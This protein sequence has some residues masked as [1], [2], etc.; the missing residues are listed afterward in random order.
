MSHKI[1]LSII[2][3]AY[4]EENHLKHCLDAIAKQTDKPDEVIVVDNNSTDKTAEIAKGYP[5]VRLI[6]ESR[7]G[8]V[9]ARDA[10]FNA[11][12]SELIGR[13]DADTRLTPGWV[14]RVKQ[15]YAKPERRDEALTGGSF[16][17]NTALPYTF[18]WIQGQIAFRANRFIMGHYILFGSNMVLPRHI[19]Q[20]VRTSVCHRTDIHEDLDLAI[21]VHRRGYAITYRQSLRVGI[22]VRRVWLHDWHKLWD[23]LMLWPTTLRVHKNKKWIL[24]WLGAVSLAMLL[25]LG[26]VV[27][28]GARIVKAGRK[29]IRRLV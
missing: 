3:P 4:N 26:G 11:S 6:H 8:I 25:P 1:S 20:A 14:A 12:R 7:Q 15:F 5:F 13:I 24:G 28:Y 10:G 17:Y 19:W 9:Y 22:A 18:G 2:I 21:H 27:E 23:N 29:A 16:L